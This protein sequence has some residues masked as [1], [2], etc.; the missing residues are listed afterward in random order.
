MKR[1]I[2]AIVFA[3][4]G[5][6]IIVG[7]IIMTNERTITVERDLTIYQEGAAPTWD[8]YTAEIRLGNT[9]NS[10]LRTG[11]VFD[12]NIYNNSSSNLDNWVVTFTVPEKSTI[13]S[14][15]DC[16][17]RIDGTTLTIAPKDYN[18]TLFS[19]DMRKFGFVLYSP[20]P[21]NFTE[22]NLKGTYVF[23]YK[24]STIMYVL[25][26]LSAIWITGIIA[27]FV[28]RFRDRYY[29]KSQEKDR[30][31]IIQ[32]INTLVNVVDAK[33]VYSIGHSKRVGEYSREIARRL[34]LGEDEVRNVYY[35]ALL[36]DI[37]KI[38][39]PDS[40]LNKPSALTNEEREIIKTHTAK[41][42]EM[43]SDFT[44]LPEIQAG[45]MYHHERYDG[46]G[47]PRGLKGE[48]IPLL[49]RIIAVADAYDAMSSERVYRERLTKEQV[50][51]EIETN[52]GKQ[53]DPK[54]A[55]IMLDMIAD[56]FTEKVIRHYLAE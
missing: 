29:R 33:D 8:A 55:Q 21:M 5:I 51:E 19:E 46:N 34:K 40:I 31:I 43:L 26:I 27:Y 28:L 2:P 7:F 48:D 13:D 14:C 10:A 4:S 17:A 15:W 53:F 30:Q 45:A 18:M 23:Q 36:H 3:I 44:A 47:Y 16:E 22:L 42:G 52:F 56:G 54:I 35:A 6:L 20:A 11:A 37:G 1:V 24:G 41:G 32:A 9:W 50:I 25:I 12:F 38:S 39:I 49:G